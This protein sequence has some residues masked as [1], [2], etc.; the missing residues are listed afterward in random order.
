MTENISRTQQKRQAKGIEEL[1]HELTELPPADLARLPCDDFLR[2][3]IRLARQLKGGAKKRQIKHIAKELRHQSVDE[4]LTFLAERKGSRLQKDRDTRQLEILR[5][6]IIQ[7]AIDCY[8]DRVDQFA[9]FTLES[10]LPS[11]DHAAKLL[12]DLPK[13]EI[14]RAA[15]NFA[16]TRKPNYSR[17]IFRILKAS[18]DKKKFSNDHEE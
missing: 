18:A 7:D 17:E 14:L 3:E 2:T 13:N 1:S 6:Q 12:P 9:Y 11:L 10:E 16:A 4:L 5:D 15:E 8:N